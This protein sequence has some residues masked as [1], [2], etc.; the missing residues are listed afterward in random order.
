[1]YV[2]YVPGL[3]KIF[4]SEETVANKDI[5]IIKTS[6]RAKIYNHDDD[7]I[8]SAVRTSNNLH[9]CYSK[10]LNPL[11]LIQRLAIH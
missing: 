2:L 3:K 8:A 5:K 10:Q 1:M 6:N 9:A 11:K 4:F 7:L